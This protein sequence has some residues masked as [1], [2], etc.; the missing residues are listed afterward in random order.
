M[1][2][3]HPSVDKLR[4]GDLLW[5]ITATQ[6]LFFAAE[7]GMV[8][9]PQRNAPATAGSPALA[10]TPRHD[11][12]R[13]LP[14]K[15]AWLAAAESLRQRL[16][17]PGDPA[18]AQALARLDA[19]GYEKFQ[20]AFGAMPQ[21]SIIE[22]GPGVGARTI[23]G[24]WRISG[25]VGLVVH[26]GTQVIDA[27]P[28]W[29][30]ASTPVGEWLG[31]YLGYEVAHRR[32]TDARG[33]GAQAAQQATQWLSRAYDWTEPLQDLETF[34]CSKLCYAAFQSVSQGQALRRPAPDLWPLASYWLTPAELLACDGLAPVP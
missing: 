9:S 21:A 18:A 12:G 16:G 5:P 25:H 4:D 2:A 28:D 13:V 29:G 20:E 19:L 3:T 15:Q 26:Q 22:P 33:W 23:L 31:E 7:R 24:G 1:P 10:R 14:E 6:L 30:V 8:P 17:Q 34:Y 32:S 11:P 27:T